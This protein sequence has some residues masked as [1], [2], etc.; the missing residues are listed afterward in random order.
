M[1]KALKQMTDALPPGKR[2]RVEA[3]AAALI[4]LEY[5][6]RKAALRQRAISPLAVTPKK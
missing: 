6:K 3:R 4:A 5:G 1:T 2:K